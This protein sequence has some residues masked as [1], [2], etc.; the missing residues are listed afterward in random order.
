MFGLT[1]PGKY[2]LRISMT[3]LISLLVKKLTCSLWTNIVFFWLN[4]NCMGF[5]VHCVWL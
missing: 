5:V 4:E 3:I 2:S 1:K